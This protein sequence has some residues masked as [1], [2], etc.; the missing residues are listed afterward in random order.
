MCKILITSICLSA[1]VI[2]PVSFAMESIKFTQNQHNE[3]IILQKKIAEFNVT[4]PVTQ[5]GLLPEDVQRNIASALAMDFL[6]DTAT[7]L[8]ESLQIGDSSY[9][10]IELAEISHD[11]T[12]LVT[13]SAENKN[14]GVHI[15]DMATAKLLH[16][17]VGYKAKINALAISFD[18]EHVVAGLEDGTVNIWDMKT[19]ILKHILET[20][21]DAVNSVAIT[22]D[23]TQI[24]T[25][26]EVQWQNRSIK[27]WSMQ[28]GNFLHHIE[29]KKDHC[30]LS[31][32][33]ISPDCK[34]MVTSSCETSL[35]FWDMAKGKL[36]RTS[37]AH[38]A[39]TICHDMVI[40]ADNNYLIVPCDKQI[41]VWD[42]KTGQEYP[43]FGGRGESIRS[44]FA[45][46]D[47][48]KL[49]VMAY[50]G[51][52]EVWS[53]AGQL[54]HVF[55]SEPMDCMKTQWAF[56]GNA[57]IFLKTLYDHDRHNVRVSDIMT[58]ALLYTLQGHS[59][60]INVLKTSSDG[61]QVFTWSSDKT[62]RIW[63]LNKSPA[64]LWLEREMLPF[65]ANLVARAYAA[66]KANQKFI[67]A[68]DTDD[69][70]LWVSLPS[71]VRDYLNLYLHV[72]LVLEAVQIHQ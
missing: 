29:D 39:N 13:V 19:G 26:S 3:D 69:M 11:D 27:I 5:E 4:C 54:L 17:L 30:C 64:R 62:A 25:V 61:T 40:T 43:A 57:K 70:L 50:G 68:S 63:S 44:L 22:P 67:I 9:G 58:G 41:Y 38:V 14:Y 36:L 45:T 71:F 42:M 15:W 35:Q 49:V 33:V 52:I 72:E 24:I 56:D 7:E 55:E 1:L 31:S 6:H 8:R 48:T 59:E 66:K 18:D 10:K 12:Q 20:S 46:L 47:K 65:Q 34:Q 60:E 2:G 32:L 28:T 23:N 51:L 37:N 53:M 21:C 16:E